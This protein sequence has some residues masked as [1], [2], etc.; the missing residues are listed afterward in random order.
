MIETRFNQAM[1]NVLLKDALDVLR[2]AGEAA[3]L[4]GVEFSQSLPG[5]RGSQ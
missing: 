2:R 3:R 5:I 1:S 4:S